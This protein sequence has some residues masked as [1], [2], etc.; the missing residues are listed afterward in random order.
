MDPPFVPRAASKG[1]LFHLL[2]AAPV[3]RKIE[4][5]VNPSKIFRQLPMG[6]VYFDRMPI[7][8]S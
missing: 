8:L 1:A 7:R 6:I 5:T 4:Q 3:F 2:M